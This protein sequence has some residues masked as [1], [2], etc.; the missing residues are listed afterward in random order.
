MP[1]IHLPRK[2]NRAS[3]KKKY[4]GCITG[5]AGQKSMNI[6]RRKVLRDYKT[7]GFSLHV[8]APNVYENNS[9]GKKSITGVLRETPE[10][11]ELFSGNLIGSMEINELVTGELYEHNS[12]L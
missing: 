2:I 11:K 6:F 7:P 3:G 5:D 1:L 12:A 8:A 10:Q 4:Y 9:P